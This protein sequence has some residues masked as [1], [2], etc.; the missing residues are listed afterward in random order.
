MLTEDQ[1]RD[2]VTAVLAQR[3]PRMSVSSIVVDPDFDEDNDPIFM[4]K[5]IFDTSE[6]NLDTKETTSLIRYIVD[7]INREDQE[8]GT[9]TGFPILSFIAKSEMEKL[10]ADSA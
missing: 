7:K 5:I 6:V 4:I 1:I 3:F 9:K 8:K 2:I 10:N